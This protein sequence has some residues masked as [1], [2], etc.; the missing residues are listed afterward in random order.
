MRK[1]EMNGVWLHRDVNLRVKK[2]ISYSA[3]IQISLSFLE[4]PA[5]YV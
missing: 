3:A 2:L 1:N 5:R 4:V